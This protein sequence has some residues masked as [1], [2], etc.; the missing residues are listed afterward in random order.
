MMAEEKKEET[1]ISKN[2][3]AKDASL[4]GQIIAALWIGGWSA[5]KFIKSG[6][7][8]VDDIIKSAIGIVV[9]FSPVYFNLIMDKVKDIKLGS[10]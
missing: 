8:G 9:C 5:F 10:L 7:A 1:T 3:K 4:L 2:I 6:G